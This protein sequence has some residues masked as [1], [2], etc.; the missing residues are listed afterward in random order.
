MKNTVKNEVESFILI[1]L[2]FLGIAYIVSISLY[3]DTPQK[4]FWQD[5]GEKYRYIESEFN[6]GYRDSTKI[7]SLKH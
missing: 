4:S 2:A 3:N 1:L 6:K 5:V 7:D